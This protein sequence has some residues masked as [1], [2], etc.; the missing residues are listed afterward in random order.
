LRAFFGSIIAGFSSKVVGRKLLIIISGL[1]FT[2]GALIMAL[3]ESV[4]VVM[5]GRFIVGLAAGISSMIVPVYL[6]EVAPT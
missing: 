1:L 4:Y 3:A 2:G 5:I 6:S